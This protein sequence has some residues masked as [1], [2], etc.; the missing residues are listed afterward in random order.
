MPKDKDLKKEEARLSYLLNRE[1]RIAK[2]RKWQV[3]NKERYRELLKRYRD[4]NK[5]KA[6]ADQKAWRERNPEKVKAGQKAWLEKNPE[7]YARA[8][9]AR[10]ARDRQKTAEKRERREIEK[11]ARLL[12]EATE[13]LRKAEERERR[14]GQDIRENKE[15]SAERREAQAKRQ[16]EMKSWGRGYLREDGKILWRYR[17]GRSCSEW[18]S[19]EEF[20]ARQEK[21]ATYRRQLED[22][23]ATKG[24][25]EQERGRRYRQKYPDRHRAQKASRR[26]KLRTPL[27]AE[28]KQIVVTLYSQAARVTKCLGI[29]FHVDHVLPL[30]LGG[31]HHPANLRVIPGRI[32]ELKRDLITPEVE[33][34]LLGRPI[35]ELDLLEAA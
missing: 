6:R 32:N 11:A 33:F 16:S 26:C 31:L 25:R 29:Q 28:Q 14:R 1:E 17:C 4:S 34:W 27:L 22:W 23:K 9:E 18:V 2:S 30:A 3:E 10:N 12:E 20:A 8:Q 24:P 19:A 21:Q 7:R 5:E 15:R 13:K 35:M